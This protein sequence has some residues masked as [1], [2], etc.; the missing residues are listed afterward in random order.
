M[1]FK[2]RESKHIMGDIL[3]PK[4]FDKSYDKQKELVNGG[5]DRENLPEQAFDKDAFKQYSFQQFF[6]TYFKMEEQYVQTTMPTG[7]SPDDNACNTVGSYYG[8]YAGGWIDTTNDRYKIKQELKEGMCQIEMNCWAF[9]NKASA[10]GRYNSGT[11]SD[12]SWYQFQLVFN[13]SVV[14]ETDRIFRQAC[15]VH[16]M[17]NVPCSA[18]PCEVKIRWRHSGRP[19]GPYYELGAPLFYFSGGNLLLI[20]RYR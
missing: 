3:E 17:A 15:T 11:V 18:G 2:P 8:T 1:P 6:Q 19:N 13:G 14:A 16:L 9:L 20:N 12:I 4:D 7:L 5:L 10:G